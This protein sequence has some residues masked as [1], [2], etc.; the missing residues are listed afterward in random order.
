MAKIDSDPLHG[1]QLHHIAERF[2]IAAPLLLDFS[3]NINPDGP[4]PAVVTTLRACLDNL[5][6]LT[7]YPD[8]QETQL[9]RAIATYACVDPKNIIVANGFVPLLEA[10]LRTLNIRSCNLPVPAFVEYRKTLERAEVAIEPHSL[11]AESSFGYN[12]ADVLVDKHN[13]ILLANPQNP[14]GVCHDIAHMRD[15]VAKALE[16]NMFV[17][18]DEAF[19]DYV[20]NHS[21]TAATEE[22][23]NLIVFR[24]VTKFHGIPGLRVAYAVT[25]PALA[26]SIHENLPPWPITTLASRAV[27]AALA[28]HS[29]A[30]QARH[31]NLH[32]RTI[33]KTNLKSLGLVVYPSTANF[34][35]FTFTRIVDSD[36]FWERMIVDHHIVLRNCANY[37]GLAPGHFRAAVRT[38]EENSRLYEALKDMLSR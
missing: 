13:A 10:T 28:D 8:L 15:I 7:H 2:G 26:S 24:S 18:L 23:L 22:F 30:D 33:L 25:N 9:K 38:Q 32:R 35:L 11:S 16:K 14:S 12:A 19:I 21:L 31:E 5:S 20:P 4:P 27:A 3:A 34:V 1:G 37:E 36:S 17:L 6:T 29:Y